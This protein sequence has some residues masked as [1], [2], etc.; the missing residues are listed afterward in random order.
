[1]LKKILL[2]LFLCSPLY[3]IE[4]LIFDK[5]H[6]MDNLTAEKIS[7]LSVNPDWLYKYNAR[8]QKGD[9]VEVRLDGFWTGPTAR[10]FNKEAFRVISVPGVK[11]DIKYMESSPTKK[12]RY[13]ILTGEG[14]K[15]TTVSNI[16]KLSITDK[17]IVSGNGKETIFVAGGFCVVI[18]ASLLLGCY[19][20]IR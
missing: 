1:M 10:G 8:Y 12:R 3:G 9:I 2:I 20:K 14:Q 19:R 7:E 11:V 13:N 18:C 17:G 6:W 4:F 15:I 16:K 5:P